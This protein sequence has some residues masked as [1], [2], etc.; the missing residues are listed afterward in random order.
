MKLTTVLLATGLAGVAA[1]DELRIY[2]WSDYIAEDTIEKFEAA[3]GIQ[4]TYDVFDSNE[5]L[6]A[7]V[8][9]GNSG[10][11]LVVPTTDFMQGQ[12][13]AGAYQKLDKSLLSNLD[14]LDGE[15]MAL[16]S[17]FDEGNAYSVPWALGTSG[18]GYNVA[19]VTE[20]LGE[21]APLN[22][23]ELLFN[24]EYASQLE[25]CGIATLD[26]A[27]EMIPAA[28]NYLGLDPNT[29]SKSD[30]EKAEELLLQ[31]RPYVRY[32]H[33]SRYISDL[34]NGNLCLV[35]GF[36]GDIFQAQARAAEAENGVEI[37]YVIPEEGAAMWADMMVIP[38]DAKN[39]ANAHK[40]IDFVL[41][42]E[43]SADIT[44]YVWYG[45]PNAAARPFIDEEILNDPG[46]FPPEGTNLF[47]YQTLPPRALRD[48]NRAWTNV[49]TG[50]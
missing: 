2:N 30:F 4:V 8:L 36:S 48:R 32:F 18:L 26:A 15:T 21:D 19:M 34:A 13:E 23:W 33:S 9:S 38:A 10:Y 12:I 35:M 49:K 11:D 39:V 3:T 40:F 47:T 50:N 25:D 22:S 31:V 41:Q 29:T 14:N 16:L 24:P 45:N 6:D 42:P 43:I 46:V 17:A 44:N 37:A 20:R 1:A 7:K 27:V 5:V 28:L